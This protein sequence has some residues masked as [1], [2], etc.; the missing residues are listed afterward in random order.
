MTKRELKKQMLCDFD[1]LR[2]RPAGNLIFGMIG[3]VM[4]RRGR[5]HSASVVEE[6][7]RNALRDWARICRAEEFLGSSWPGLSRSPRF[8]MN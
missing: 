3:P 5:L 8:S 2:E 6:E 4:Y 7:R 1:S